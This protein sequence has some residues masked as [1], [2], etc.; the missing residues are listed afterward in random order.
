[1]PTELQASSQL[2][3]RFGSFDVSIFVDAKGFEHLALTSGKVTDGALVRVHSE[4]ATGDIMGS[5]RCDCR[6][7]LEL[8]MKKIGAEGGLLIYIRDHEGRGIGLANKI[9]AYALQDQ[10]L[11]TVD[12]NVKLGFAPDQ[13]NYDVAIAILKH[14]GLKN[15]RLLTNNRKKIDALKSAGIHVTEQ[16]PLWVASNPHNEKYLETKR[17][18]MGHIGG[19]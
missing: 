8:S 11:D 16:V 12:A 17:E 13:R 3:T 6:D 4:C 1:M 15:I 14:F 9:K 2:P 5:L 7:Q 18:R 10:G 19:K